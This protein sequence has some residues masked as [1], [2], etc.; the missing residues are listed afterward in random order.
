[1]SRE[2]LIIVGPD[3]PDRRARRRDAVTHAAE[4]VPGFAAVRVEE[5]PR[6]CLAIVETGPG[7]GT[8][9]WLVRRRGSLEACL[10]LTEAGL[11][12][13]RAGDGAAVGAEH[14]HVRVNVDDAGRVV[15]AVDG[16]ATIPLY[17][18]EHEGRGFA[19][20][21]LASLV[22][23]GLPADL[24]QE[25][26]LEYLA[27]HHPLGQRTILSHAA[28]LAPGGTL[29]FDG[30]AWRSSAQALFVPDP[31]ARSDDMVVDDFRQTWAEVIR[32]VHERHEQR[33]LLVGLSGGLDSRAIVAQ[34]AA[35]GERPVT[36]TYGDAGVI[37]VEVARNIAS[38][39]ML[40]HMVL[41]V[42]DDRVLRDLV[43]IA[44]RMDGAHSP[45]EMYELWF[46]D[47]LRS[48]GDVVVNGLAGGP[49]WGDDRSVGLDSREDVQ[50]QVWRRYGPAVAGLRPLLADQHRDQ[51]GTRIRSA[52]AASMSPFDFS[53]RADMVVFW[54]L[55]NR[56]NRWGNMLFSSLRRAGLPLEAPFLDARFLRISARLTPEQRRHGN[57]YLRIHREVLATTADIPRGDDGNRLTD[58]DH[59]YW[60]A[61][62]GYARQ[63]VDLGRRHPLAAARRVGRRGLHVTAA[64]VRSKT[65][66]AT[67]ADALD[68]RADSFPIALWARTRP[69][70]RQRL[71]DFL[72]PAAE[73]DDLLDA[74][75]VESATDDLRRGRP[76]HDVPMLGRVATLAAWVDDHEQRV[77]A[78]QEVETS[79]G[80][81]SA[82]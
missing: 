77:G 9:S 59:V 21:H 3:H 24:D 60:S 53:R 74:A 42:S 36:Y 70:F 40:P 72:A 29:V 50:R 1:M 78:R 23:L 10:A 35:L 27:M 43:P 51:A 32:D 52:I 54:K 37:E 22:S 38:R 2:L 44:R 5:T 30:G 55:A 4:Q 28:L 65:G 13:G 81:G 7:G 56:Q 73:L 75:A 19:S 6:V 79:V 16:M 33:R 68:R 26:A 31:D 76:T 20:T 61:D 12:A 39:L 47:R 15:I 80:P 66:I 64:T 18:G 46:A 25:G 41:P 49:L 45:T 34:S 71:A 82:S 62:T 63:L 48:L 69:V 67:P 58:L 17:W 14:G 57:L 8:R 11:R